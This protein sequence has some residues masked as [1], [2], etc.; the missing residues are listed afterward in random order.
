MQYSIRMYI[1]QKHCP[2]RFFFSHIRTYVASFS[3][4]PSYIHNFFFL[5]KVCATYMVFEVI[6]QA[7]VCRKISE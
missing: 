6:T 3:L 7:T 5:I 4:K 2:I 1:Y